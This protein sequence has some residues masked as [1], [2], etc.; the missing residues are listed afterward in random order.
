L[1]ERSLLADVRQ[2]ILKARESIARTVDSGLTL[3][4]WSVG[5]RIRKD[6]LR[7]KRAEC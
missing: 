1:T 5:A 7:E 2:M 6:I 3:L 4:Y